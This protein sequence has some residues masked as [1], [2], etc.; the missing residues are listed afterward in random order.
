MIEDKI[1]DYL[2]QFK[3]FSGYYGKTYENKADE[4]AHDIAEI[5]AKEQK[6]LN[7]EEVEKIIKHFTSH[8]NPTPAGLGIMFDKGCWI[9]VYDAICNLAYKPIDCYS[10]TGE[11]INEREG[12]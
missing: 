9:E 6:Y 1:K 11:I 10:K 7:R 12:K 8:I 2:K 4:L 5:V 3:I